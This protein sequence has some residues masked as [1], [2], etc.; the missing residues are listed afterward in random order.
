MC[1]NYADNDKR[2]KVIHN[3]ENKGLLRSREIGYE[4]AAG[5]WICFFNHDDCMNLKVIEYLM[6]CVD[7]KTDIIASKY[8]NIINNV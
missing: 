7:E 2:I 5:E 6:H 3:T 4:Q 8:R 1:Y